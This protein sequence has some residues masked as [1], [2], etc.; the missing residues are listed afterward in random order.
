VTGVTQSVAGQEKSSRHS[1]AG[2]KR[3]GPFGHGETLES[4]RRGVPATAGTPGE[5]LPSV[6][7]FWRLPKLRLAV[8]WNRV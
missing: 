7:S 2:G 3:M 1:P 5:T 4:S 8:R 6:V